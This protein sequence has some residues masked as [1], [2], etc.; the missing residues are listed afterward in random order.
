MSNLQPFQFGNAEIRFVGTV[1]KPEWVAADVI[2]VLYPESN[3]RNRAS[4]LRRIPSEWR[5]EKRILAP[6]GNAEEKSTMRSSH[7]GSGEDSTID[8]VAGSHRENHIMR[9]SHVV[10][11]KSSPEEDR[12]RDVATITEPGLYHLIIRSNSPIAV[13]FQKWVFEE[14]LPSIR[15]TGGYGVFR[16]FS[17]PILTLPEAVALTEVA[18]LAVQSDK[19]SVHV[20]DQIADAVDPN[21]ERFTHHDIGMK[22]CKVMNTLESYFHER[23]RLADALIVMPGRLENFIGQAVAYL[24]SCPNRQSDWREIAHSI[25]WLED[26]Y[27]AS[28][29]CKELPNDSHLAML[30]HAVLDCIEKQGRGHWITP[31]PRRNRSMTPTIFQLND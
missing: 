15:K 28:W 24:E 17:H 29:G 19:G 22:H 20:I 7:T 12:Y 5:N 23:N 9:S 21:Y 25:E 30:I 18:A 11:K 4:Y 6:Y 10:T 26:S 27:E 13:P 8:E 31:K 16:E 2:A 1:D 14:V 3:A